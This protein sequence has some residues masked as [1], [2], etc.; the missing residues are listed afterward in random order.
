MPDGGERPN[1]IMTPELMLLGEKALEAGVSEE[2]LG[3]ILSDALDEGAVGLVE[4]LWKDAPRMLAE[5]D[6]IRS[7]FEQRLQARWRRPLEL[8]EMVLV[9]CMEAGSDLH[10]DLTQEEGPVSDHP[11]KLQALTLLHARA[12]MVANEV[13]A[14]LR[15]GPNEVSADD[16][17]TLKGIALLLNEAGDAFATC[18]T[19]LRDETEAGE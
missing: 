5:H 14:L 13:F 6:E 17:V 15:A 1:R 3:K 11:V 19:E 16:L 4:R 10:D 7:G 18:E 2:T 12:C 8:Y 9:C